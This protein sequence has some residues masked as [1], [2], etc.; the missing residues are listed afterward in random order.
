MAGTFGCAALQADIPSL[1]SNVNAHSASINRLRAQSDELKGR[2]DALA[3][4]QQEFASGAAAQAKLGLQIDRL[5]AR[6]NELSGN[7]DEVSQRLKDTGAKVERLSALEARLAAL[8][9]KTGLAQAQL[10]ALSS[11][12][13]AVYEDGLKLLRSGQPEAARKRLADYLKTNPEGDLAPNAQ[14][15]LAESYYDQERY[16]EAVVE[17]QNVIDHYPRAEKV[18]GAL[19]KQAM[20]FQRLKSPQN[21]KLLLEK[22]IEKYPASSQAELAKKELAGLKGAESAKPAPEPKKKK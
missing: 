18:A 21:A 12:P 4:R 15:W 2:I 17:Y 14:Y 6:L 11:N 16:E 10:Q 5:E 1:E 19:L 22:L 7:V 3:A 13:S 8:E 9:E 20:S